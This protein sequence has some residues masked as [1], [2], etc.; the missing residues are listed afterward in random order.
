MVLLLWVV[1][2]GT[3]VSFPLF[4][5]LRELLEPAVPPL[6][7][8]VLPY[9]AS[10]VVFGSNV[11]VLAARGLAALLSWQVAM[12]PAIDPWLLAVQR[13]GELSGIVVAAALPA[14]LVALW[15]GRQRTVTGTRAVPMAR[16]PLAIALVWTV[17][18]SQPLFG[19]M[20]RV[21][22]PV[23]T[24]LMLPPV[25][26]AETEPPSATEWCAYQLH[27]SSFACEADRMTPYAVRPESVDGYGFKG[28][29]CVSAA[30]VPRPECVGRGSSGI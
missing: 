25:A 1:V 21:L 26:A 30:D 20:G 11:A 24:W 14:W 19:L 16:V 17:V 10:L 15:S 28:A 18:V 5:P 3:A 6:R 4:V 2:M 9:M 13:V 22:F 12:A 7:G 23:D 29:R 8:V 27:P